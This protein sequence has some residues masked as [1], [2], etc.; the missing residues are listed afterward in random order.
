LYIYQGE[1]LGLADADLPDTARQDPVFIRTQGEQL[2][3]DGARVPLPWS[4]T[5]APYGFS[6]AGA[7]PTWL[8]QP[9]DWADKTVAAEAGDEYSTMSLYRHALHIRAEHPALGEGDGTV[10]WLAAPEGVLAFAREPGFVAI[11]NTT[12]APR[13]VEITGTL[14]LSSGIDPDVAGDAVTVPASTTVWLQV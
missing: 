11:A 9:A 6:P 12:A 1:E 7:A 13:T 4:G 5:S 8:P 10:Q 2:G 3:R 14:L